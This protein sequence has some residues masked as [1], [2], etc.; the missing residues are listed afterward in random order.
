MKAL[1]RGLPVLAAFLAGLFLGR[2][3]PRTVSVVRPDTVVRVLR[4]TL[5]LQRVSVRTLRETV[6]TKPSS[7]IVKLVYK[8]PYVRFLLADTLSARWREAKVGTT[9]FYVSDTLVGR[10]VEE[11]ESF[12]TWWVAAGLDNLRGAYAVAGVRWGK[13]SA[14]AG[15]NAEKRVFSGLEVRF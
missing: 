1:L 8:P 4:D 11:R 12:R 2:G 13:L 9:A 6:W 3:R 10:V 5:Y 14:Y 15:M 7:C